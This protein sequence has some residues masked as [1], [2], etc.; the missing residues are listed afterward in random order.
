MKNLKRIFFIL[1][2]VLSLGLIACEKS[3]DDTGFNTT[4]S[5]LGTP[6]SNEIWFV[7]T[8]ESRLLALNDTAFD[9][10]IEE[11][12]YSEFGINIIRFADTVTTIKEE[13]FSSCTNLFNISLPNTITTIE[14]RA[15]LNCTNMECITL[16]TR[17]RSCGAGAF[18]NCIN[19]H[20]VHTPSIECWCRISFADMTANPAYFASGFIINDARVINVSIP[21]NITTLSQYLF[22]NNIYLKSIEIPSSVNEIGS[23]AF[24]E[25]S[26]LSKVKI[27]DIEAWCSIDFEDQM[28]NPLSIAGALY[29]N[30]ALAT[31]ISI[32]S[33]K[34]IKSHAFIQ[35]TSLKTVSIADTVQEIEEEAFRA[36]SVLTS[37]TIGVGVIDIGDRAFMGCKRLKKVICNATEPPFLG[38]NVFDHNA[39]ERTIAVPAQ[40][41]NSYLAN[42]VWSDYKE[43]IVTIE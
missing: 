43:S 8:D 22:Y 3:N 9:A 14:D 4:I 36:C 32:T 27:S 18:D 23:N 13:A 29:L 16:G 2:L 34:D 24:G 42:R 28:A 41:L 15:F 26:A 12:E 39:D 25:C 35:C 21:E 17:L 5:S 37:V 19:L 30:G 1:S 20:S 10:T 38:A 33:V 6:D 31:H 40:S 11:I 7:T